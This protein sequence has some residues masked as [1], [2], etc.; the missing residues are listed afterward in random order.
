MSSC[1]DLE[2]EELLQDDDMS[3][4]SSVQSHI[5]HS[6][7][8]AVPRFLESHQTTTSTKSSS[9]VV[10]P[11]SVTD[12]SYSRLLSASYWSLTSR[13][14]ELP[15]ESEGSI[16]ARQVSSSFLSR[17]QRPV[18]GC[19]NVHTAPDVLA[20]Y[21]KTDQQVY[22][23]AVR[24]LRDYEW[25]VMETS[26]EARAIGRWRNI[27]EYNFHACELGQQLMSMM[28]ADATEQDIQDTISDTFG[29][30]NWKT[31][32]KS[33]G[34]ILRFI[35]WV[36][37]DFSG[38]VPSGKLAL[39]PNELLVYQYIVHL[40]RTEA[41][42]SSAMSLVQA[43]TF[44]KH[45]IG[46]KNV[47]QI[48]ESG[49][50]K[51]AAMKMLAEKRPL[52]QSQPLDCRQILALESAACHAPNVIDRVAAGT[53]CCILYA[54]ARFGD[55]Q[56]T[57]KILWDLNEDLSRG[58]IELQARQVKTAGTAEKKSRFL[59]MTAP[60]RGISG[61]NWANAWMKARIET[62]L[63]MSDLGDVPL[64]PAPSL[65]GG[66]CKR[67]LSTG[68]AISW[69]H[70]I[71]R[72]YGVA[73][74][75]GVKIHSLKVTLLSWAAKRGLP[76]DVRK[77]LGYHIDSNEMSMMTYSRDAMARPLRKL[78]A[79]LAEVRLGTF[80]PDS[81]RSGRL[82]PNL[83]RDKPPQ[84][85]DIEIT[86]EA[87]DD[88]Y[89][90]QNQ[91]FPSAVTDLVLPPEEEHVSESSD[92]SSESEPDIE[93]RVIRTSI[94]NARKTPFQFKCVDCQIYQH[95]KYKTLHVMPNT[96]SS[97]FKCGRVLHKGYTKIKVD[98]RFRWPKCGQCYF[99][100]DADMDLPRDA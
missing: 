48:L 73:Y 51:G 55:A 24:R 44:A 57:E 70:E 97:R 95:V 6:N 32:V 62:H 22:T 27:I 77:A 41:S 99:D 54:R 66:W 33:A 10:V 88:W 45:T 58:Y 67:P 15:W 96:E 84:E 92:S 26:N 5:L 34:S 89:H 71:F 19:L 64:L 43:F 68:E 12:D 72:I 38:L 53:F 49:R 94:P 90:V 80:D 78:E 61:L 56:R 31:L 50:I 17:F 30:K 47:D 35:E 100:L 1:I 65:Q 85:E 18:L 52:Q 14:I 60:V 8:D 75:P 29:L 42:P 9:S 37:T 46:L 2:D 7:S 76:P 23:R 59:P 79:M 69:L 16:L 4:H 81:S 74:S 86:A 20:D 13:P 82:V 40:R 98:L 91:E 28:D 21:D 3:Q 11:A 87:N 39:P 93:E 83:E 36:A 25:K 63:P